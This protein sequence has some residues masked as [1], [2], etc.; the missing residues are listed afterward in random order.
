MIFFEIMIVQT[1]K[2]K[3]KDELCFRE[4]VCIMKEEWMKDEV[5]SGKPK[6]MKMFV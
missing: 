2:C 5:G 1:Q 4:E 3:T 6:W